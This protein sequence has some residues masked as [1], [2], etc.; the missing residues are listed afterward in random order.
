IGKSMRGLFRERP[1]LCRATDLAALVAE[2]DETA[3]GQ[4]VKMVPHRHC[5]HAEAARDLLGRLRPLG[6]QLEKDLVAGWPRWLHGLLARRHGR[7]LY[8]KE[9]LSQG[10]S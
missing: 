2:R 4:G 1:D 5:R 8:K 9:R 7:T 10:K 3:F 6:F